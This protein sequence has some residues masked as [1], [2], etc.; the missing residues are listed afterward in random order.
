MTGKG[1]MVND[2]HV[3]GI[4]IQLESRWAHQLSVISRHAFKARGPLNRYPQ[5]AD[6]Y[7]GNFFACVVNL[8]GRAP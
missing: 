1:R 3:S 2:V 7:W 4:E 8:W 5:V 6:N